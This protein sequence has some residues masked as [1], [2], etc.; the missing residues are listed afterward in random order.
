MQV[1][2]NI[3][4]DHIRFFV[5]ILDLF[6]KKFDQEILSTEE[7]YETALTLSREQTCEALDASKG[8]IFDEKLV[9][10][11]KISFGIIMICAVKANLTFKL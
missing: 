7:S 5:E 2:T 6:G 8:I 9:K 11:E 4:N 10:Y 1:E 3:V